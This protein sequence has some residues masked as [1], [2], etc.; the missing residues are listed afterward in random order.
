[1]KV[2]I[3]YGLTAYGYADDIGSTIEIVDKE[4][5][6]SLVNKGLVKVEKEKQESKSK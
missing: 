6:D 3:L 5:A 2:V 1:M 4:L